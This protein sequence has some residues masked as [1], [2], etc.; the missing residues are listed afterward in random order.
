MAAGVWSTLL[1]VGIGVLVALVG[2]WLALGYWRR[3]CWR[4]EITLLQVLADPDG[5][6]AMERLERRRS[7]QDDDTFC[8]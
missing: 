5:L 2:E 4:A 6:A 8:A 3:R 7:R 1:G